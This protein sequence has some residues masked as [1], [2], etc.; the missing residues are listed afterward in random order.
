[1]AQ[2]TWFQAVEIGLLQSLALIPGF[3]RTGVAL[4]GGLLAG[5]SHE[6]ALRFSL[7][8]ATPILG[9]A[10]LFRLPGLILQ[11]ENASIVPIVAI[12]VATGVFASLSVRFVTKY[13]E[14]Q[15]LWPFA[16]YC[17]GGGLFVLVYFFLV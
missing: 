1:M 14:T 2:L 6:D 3:S 16:L 10:S 9:I 11:A 15:K 4:A 5:L 13:F 12:V 17:V 8:L 7:L